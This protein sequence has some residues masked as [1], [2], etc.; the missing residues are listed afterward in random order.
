MTG[1]NPLSQ[2]HNRAASAAERA[3]NLSESSLLSVLEEVC[4]LQM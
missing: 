3:G 1:H 4:P 2:P